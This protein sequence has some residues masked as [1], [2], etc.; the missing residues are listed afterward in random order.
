MKPITNKTVRVVSGS[1]VVLSII[2][3]IGAIGFLYAIVNVFNMDVSSGV[4]KWFIMA[5]IGISTYYLAF[6]VLSWALLRKRKTS[7]PITA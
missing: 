2:S 6:S 1:S 4:V 5:V 3:I 7:A